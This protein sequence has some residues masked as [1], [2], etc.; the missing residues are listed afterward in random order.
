[1]VARGME[2]GSSSGIGLDRR[3]GLREPNAAS[4]ARPAMS[5]YLARE[6]GKIADGD[7]HEQLRTHLERVR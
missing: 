2:R 1:M 7:R 6:S 4:T 5:W 3:I